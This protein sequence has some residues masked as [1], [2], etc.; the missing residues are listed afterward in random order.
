MAAI[1]SWIPAI[2][3][4]ICLMSLTC[5]PVKTERFT[6]E[7]KGAL[8]EIMHEG[9]IS[10]RIDLKTL[11]KH[12]NLYA[13]GSVEGLK[14][15]I[16]IL[17]GKSYISE[18]RNKKTYTVQ[19]FDRKA[20]LLVYTQ[21]AEWTDLRVPD[22][23]TTYKM[24]EQFLF[25]L[26]GKYGIQPEK[27]F[28]FLLEGKIASLDWHVIDWDQND[29]EH[30]H[31]KHRNSGIKGTLQNADVALLGF[32]SEKHRGI[33]THRDTYMHIHVHAPSENLSAHVDD[34][35]LAPGM[36]VKIPKL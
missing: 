1:N 13:L 6:V 22:S 17:N 2:P 20:S 11:E 19:A 30:T 5:K 24:L 3:V 7:Y 28:P 14:G 4:A 36:K 25:D 12:P 10:G 26:S 16:I 18:V 27:A 15:E 33:F 35:I 32:Y 23:I 29:T 8:R 9:D 34:L 21:V 31:E